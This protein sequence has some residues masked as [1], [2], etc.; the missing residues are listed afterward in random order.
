MAS[1]TITGLKRWSCQNKE[2]PP[3][4]QVK[5]L[6]IYDFDNTLFM[7]PLP[8]PKL[9]T[10]PTVGHLQT[11]ES[12][13]NGGWWHDHHILE[14]TGEG[15]EKEEPRAWEGWWNEQI[16]NL[17]ELSMQQKDALTVLL[18][19]R[20]EHNFADLV[21][22]IVASKKLQFDMVCLKPRVGP[23]NQRFP[24]TMLFKKALLEDIVYT[25]KDAEEIRVYEDRPKHTKGFREYFEQLNKSLLLPTAPIP[26]KPI[27]AEVIQVAEG[28]A[29]LDPVVETAEVQR[30]INSHNASLGAG[31]TFSNSPR[32]QIKRTV[33]F[34]GYLIS[35]A[36]TAKLVTLINL[37]SGMPQSEVKFLANNILITPRPCPK[38]IL[39][40]VGGIG[41]KVIWQIT[42]TAVYE[43]KIWAARVAP[44]H[45]NTTFYSEN[46][47]P[48]V[49]LALR[50]G[51][52]PIDAKNI[53]N[54]QPVSAE[55][56][57]IFETVVGEKVQLR[58]EQ[59]VEGEGEWESLFANKSNRR[60][61]PQ[62]DDEN[63]RSQNLPPTGPQHGRV[64][65]DENRRP[66]GNSNNNYRGGTQNRGRGN[67]GGRHAPYNG[68]GGRGNNRGSGGGGRGRGR[69]SG[70]GGYKSLDD[71]TDSPKYGQG[72]AYQNPNL[73]PSYDDSPSQGFGTQGEGYNAVFPPI[74]GTG[75]GNG[76][77]WANAGA[78]VL[79]HGF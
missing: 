68:R 26:R 2:L 24:S 40:K 53:Q 22:R 54:W 46:P 56:Q 63:A 78:G 58:V 73:Q 57:F 3:V 8:N 55:R 10:G 41:N 31:N 33:Y 77:N 43:N 1:Y 29:N 7:S 30:M 45:S 51:A 5:A 36:D 19:G 9:W 72:G 64:G 12:F 61:H 14:A 76:N 62:E 79:P 21:K 71:M 52:R 17:V 23:N 25:Y 74:G 75:Y 34:T 4:P 44:M 38:S 15:L 42:G 11:Q 47:V 65:A 60:R 59:E 48:I 37:P 13:A 32:L 49:V 6:H 28:A 35:P 39:D 16:V 69:G 20:G 27:T 50:K 70:Y 67:G 18:T 66:H